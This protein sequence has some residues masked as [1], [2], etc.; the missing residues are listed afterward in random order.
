MRVFRDDARDTIVDLGRG[1]RDLEIGDSKGALAL[2][3]KVFKDGVG[4]RSS[5]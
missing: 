3:M 2:E 1:L 4:E 5:W